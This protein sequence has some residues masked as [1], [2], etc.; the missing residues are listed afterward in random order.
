MILIC[1]RSQ[2]LGAFVAL[3]A[4]LVLLAILSRDAYPSPSV[5]VIWLT[6]LGALLTGLV[7]AW[8][9]RDLRKP[10]DNPLRHGLSSLA[11]GAVVGGLIANLSL[12]TLVRYTASQPHT[13][14]ISYE[15][16]PGWKNCVFGV[17]FED[18][19]LLSRIRVCGPRWKL[20]ATPNVG[21]LQIAELSG[22]YG[23]VLQQVTTG[24]E[25]PR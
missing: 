1:G 5:P 9:L 20:P 24:H 3:V 19:V 22:P 4:L 6:V 18:P 21:V 13:E 23:V 16:T 25:S 17:T 8:L 15:V 10:L 11:V 12:D 7:A 2:L 14:W